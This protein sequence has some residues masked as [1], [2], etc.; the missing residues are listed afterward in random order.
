MKLLN[1]V[2]RVQNIRRVDIEL[3]TEDLTGYKNCTDCGV[4]LDQLECVRDSLGI[5]TG[6]LWI[7]L[8]NRVPD[9]AAAEVIT[10]L[11]EI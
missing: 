6:G 3:I 8:V 4:F 10:V 9:V 2:Y 5:E 11:W 7:G 1:G